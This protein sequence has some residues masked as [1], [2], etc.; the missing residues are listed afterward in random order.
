MRRAI[1]AGGFL[2][3][4]VIGPRSQAQQPAAVPAQA[5][6]TGVIAGRLVR[7][8]NNQPV[9]KAQVALSAPANRIDRMTTSDAD[10]RYSFDKLP[11][12]EYSIVAS[13]PGYV[14]MVFGARRP[15]RGV[16]GTPITLVQ[17]RE[18]RQR[19]SPD[20]PRECDLRN[21]A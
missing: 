10:G 14:D 7:V 5:A 19:R 3:L 17:G 21:G 20:A 11:A 12:G 1:A 15:G 13:K 8:D 6:A 16:A 18:D 9:R 2:V 4:S